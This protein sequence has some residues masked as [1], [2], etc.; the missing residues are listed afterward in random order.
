MRD[1]DDS[2][3][4]SSEAEQG[5][6]TKNFQQKIESK[7]H[8][9]RIKALGRVTSILSLPYLHRQQELDLQD[10]KLIKGFYRRALNDY[11][12][13]E[14]KPLLDDNCDD[15]YSDNFDAYESEDS[16]AS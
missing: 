12:F 13:L 15:S 5:N 14:N 10:K 3:T 16:Y 2:Q 7:N 9:Y 1:A 4:S 11:K 6:F 8:W